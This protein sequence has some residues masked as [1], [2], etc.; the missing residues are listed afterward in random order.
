MSRFLASAL[1]ALV[2]SP[3]QSLAKSPSGSENPEV[4]VPYTTLSVSLASVA[5]MLIEWIDRSSGHAEWMAA[6]QTV[7]GWE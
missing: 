4:G 5:A 2:R 1:I 3:A 7:V 6:T